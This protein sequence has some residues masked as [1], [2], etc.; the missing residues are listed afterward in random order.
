MKIYLQIYFVREER[1]NSKKRKLYINK[2][3]PIVVFPT[4]LDHFERTFFALL[5]RTTKKVS[6][7]IGEEALVQVAEERSWPKK[8][9][10]ERLSRQEMWQL[11]TMLLSIFYRM[12]DSCLL[13]AVTRWPKIIQD[14]DTLRNLYEIV[15][16]KIADMLVAF[17]E[18]QEDSALLKRALDAH[19]I[20]RIGGI[21]ALLGYQQVY[22][23]FKMKKE[24]ESVIDSLWNI[25]KDIRN[26]IYRE[27]KTYGFKLDKSDD[28]R[29]LLQLCK[30]NIEQNLKKIDC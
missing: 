11:H 10:S 20:E 21:R 30:Y 22:K 17:T 24:I 8:N 27:P 3:N 25:N 13:Q 29:K 6:T 9:T 26:S 18:K 12:I 1:E 5:D 2:D 19:I 4:K 28:W 15:F 7:S 14:K 16:T 23:D